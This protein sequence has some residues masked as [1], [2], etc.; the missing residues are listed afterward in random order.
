MDNEPICCVVCKKQEPERNKL[1]TCMYC[2]SSAHFKCRNIIGSAIN[3]VR[4]NMYFCTT[5]CSE[6]YKRIVDMQTNHSSMISSLTSELKATVSSVVADQMVNVKNEVRS[7][8][9]AI[10]KSQDFL[11]AKFDD[12]VSDFKDLKTE[13]ECLKQR[14]N[15]LTESHSKLTSFVHQLEANVDKSDR[16]AISKN[17]VL[18][19]LPCIQN[20]NVLATVH[21]TIAQVGAQIEH[22]SIVS[23]TRLFVSNKSNVMIPI[24]IEFKDVSVKEMVL[25]KKREFG[26]IVS[27]NINENFLV[28]GKPTT[29]SIRDELTPLSLDLLRKMRESQELLKIKFVWPGRGGGI[30]V[31]K[32]EDSKPD[33]IKTR[34]DL[35][36]IMNAY[37]VA[38]NQSPSPKR[39]KNVY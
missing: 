19:G 7:V 30:L 36:R 34:D 3:R 14:I 8:T 33:V 9:T 17:A 29:V 6:I 23:A 16:K 11:S 22:D 25:S 35:N 10:E 5:S 1:I 2:F 15:E 38:M 31:K 28:N 4:A 21:N 18:L 39:K 13:N 32:H 12:I 27:T 37:S 24:Q 26:K 20:E